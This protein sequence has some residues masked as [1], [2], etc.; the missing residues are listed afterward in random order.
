MAFLIGSD[1]KLVLVKNG[2]SLN[3]EDD[4]PKLK[5]LLAK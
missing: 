5:F 4:N 3:L 1:P 2:L